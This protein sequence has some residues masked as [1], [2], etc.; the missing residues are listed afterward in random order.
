MKTI[1][2]LG[3]LIF[4]LFV[5]VVFSDGIHHITTHFNF[6]FTKDDIEQYALILAALVFLSI[7]GSRK[8]KR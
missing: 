4:I 6:D 3:F 8:N 5:L 1:Q 2:A 7:K